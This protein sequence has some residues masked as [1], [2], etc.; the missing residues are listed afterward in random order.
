MFLAACGTKKANQTE[1][2]AASA[3]PTNKAKSNLTPPAKAASAAATAPSGEDLL[4]I[5]S[6]VMIIDGPGGEEPTAREWAMLDGDPQSGWAVEEAKAFAKPVVLELPARSRIRSFVVDEGKCELESLLHHEFDVEMSDESALSGFKKIAHLKPNRIADGLVFNVTADVPGRWLRITT[7]V[8]PQG[9]DGATQLQIQNLHAYGERL[10]PIAM[11]QVTGHYESE[12]IGNFNLTQDGAQVSGC[13]E[14]ATKPLSGVLDGRV[15]R[16][17]WEHNEKDDHG[18][19]VLVFGDGRVFGAYW[20]EGVENP[21]LFPIWAKR[22]STKPQPCPKEKA[23]PIAAAIAATGRVRLYGINFDT[24]KDVLR[25]ESKPTLDQVVAYMKANN[26]RLRIEGHTD[27]RGGADHNQ[28]LS[29]ARAASVKKY[30]VDAG[31][32]AGRLETQGFG[33]SKPTAPNNS[34]I[35]RAANRR[36]ELVKI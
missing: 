26:V 6:G 34:D 24:D 17:Q 20:N 12:D 18:P 23:D 25:P 27:D 31:I 33:A 29:D 16:V 35:G 10:A 15:L 3:A 2:A 8:R 13:A 19:M 32:A 9:D 5:T 7:L 28:T 14:K 21:P 1:S 36:V 4:A 30:L 22:T 11:P